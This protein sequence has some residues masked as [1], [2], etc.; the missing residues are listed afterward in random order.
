MKPG[1]SIKA[2]GA[3]LLSFLF[4]ATVSLFIKLE[5][6]AGT[7]IPQVLFIQFST[8]LLIAS[9][10]ASRERFSELRTNKLRFQ[11]IRGVTGVLAFTCYSLAV[12][13]IP[14][15]NAVLL[16]N[17]TPLFIPKITLIWLKV[18]VDERVWRGILV[19]FIGIILILDP[20]AEGF[21]KIGDMFG[22]ASGIFLAIGYVA[23]RILAKS[24]SLISVVFYYSLIAVIMTAPFAFSSQHLPAT[25]TLI[26]GILSGILFVS[27]LALLQYSYKIADAVKL[28]PLNFSLIVFTGIFDWLIFD[29]IPGTMEIA[30]IILVSA[31]GI[32]SIT[33]HQRTVS[34]S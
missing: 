12:T 5:T 13:R 11:I 30:G 8:S 3:A 33:L 22:L 26:Y 16:N 32:I 19:G 28:S 4:L 17:T 29:H 10:F 6:V 14:L 7:P 15:V 23:L 21:L 34:Y 20:T 24:D 31:G 1:Q 25:A 27:Y 2:A 18:K 9:A